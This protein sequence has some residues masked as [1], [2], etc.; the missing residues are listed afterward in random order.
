MSELI[1]G[2]RPGSTFLHRMPAG[3][4]LLALA[5]IAIVLVIVRGP[6]SSLI[7]VACALAL[8]LWSGMG[9]HRL[10]RTLRGFALVM[11]LLGGYQ[12]WQ[13]GWPRAIETVG[14]LVALILLATVMTTTTP[15][16]Q[17]LDAITRALRPFR[18]VGVNPERVALA[19]SL[20]L[21]TIPAAVEIA[22]ETRDAA[23]ARGLDRSPRAR[24]TPTVIRMVAH[25]RATG[26]ALHARGL[27]D[28]PDEAQAADSS[29]L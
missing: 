14:D 5:V 28:D 29:A 11:V 4:K 8:C 3:A 21:R 9:W 7:A 12:A 25:A 24:L 1:S 15:V 10:G 19:F 17:V 13:R 27:G 6:A 2:F 22:G 16:D 26:D 20:T 18:R 23:R